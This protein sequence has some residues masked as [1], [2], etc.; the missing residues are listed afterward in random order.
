MKNTP[1]IKCVIWDLDGT[2][3]N[4]TLLED[5]DVELKPSVID[6]IRALD[7]RGILQSV[8]SKNDHDVAWP[9]L[10]SMELGQYFLH[11]QINWSGKADS[12]R[13]IGERLGIG[14]DTLAFIDDRVEERDEVHFFLPQV[15]VIDAADIGSILDLPRLQSGAVT[16]DARARRQMY[17][18]D[19]A[20]TD[21]E[22]KFAGTRDAFLQTLGMQMV[23]SRASTDDLRRVEELT[24]RTNQLNTTGRT[25]SLEALEA[26]ANSPDHLLLIAKLEDRHGSYGTIGLTLVE[27]NATAWTIQLLIMSCRV[28]TRGVGTVLLGY[29]LRLATASGVRLRADFVHTERNRQMYMTYKF[30]GFH[31]QA[32]AAESIVLEHDLRR[33]NPYPSYISVTSE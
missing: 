14:L 6:T 12:V 33:I 4:G 21:A 3:W 7:G 22:E 27:K 26:L 5:R 29:L 30:S 17:Q 13:A 9:V 18:A 31:E 1:S 28:I 2:I 23:I 8:A 25:Y 20:R 15:T 16:S 10:E 19:I 32:N 24:L 11:P